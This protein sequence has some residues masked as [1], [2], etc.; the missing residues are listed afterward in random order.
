M[1]CESCNKHEAT[2]RYTHIVE[3]KKKTVN[4]C[5][6]CAPKEEDHQ[7]T[8]VVTSA[9][10]KKVVAELS[11]LTAAEG[12][13]AAQCAECGMSY[14]EFKKAGRF[15][16][17]GC[18]NAFGEQ[19]ER[20][21]KRIHGSARH[22]GKGRVKQR[23]LLSPEEEIVQL[24]QALEGAVAEEAFER[25]AELRDRIVQLEKGTTEESL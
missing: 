23:Q 4:L 18:Y 10:G 13:S 17:P 14:Q 11:Q 15:G 22:C 9:S 3:N 2:I 8:G 19:L 20:L 12:A 1:I 21:L 5:S 24:R 16:C 6:S 25:A 7:A